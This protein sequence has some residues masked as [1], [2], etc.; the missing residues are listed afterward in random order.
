MER[1][2]LLSKLACLITAMVMTVAPLSSQEKS[3]NLAA[4]GFRYLVQNQRMVEANQVL[5]AMPLEF[6]HR[7]DIRESMVMLFI[8]RGD[9][10]LAL[11]H[12]GDLAVSDPVAGNWMLA[13]IHARLGNI[14]DALFFLARHLEQPGH[15]PEREIKL[16]DA[17]SGFDRNRQW[18]ALWQREWYSAW[19]QDLAEAL[20]LF[21]KGET[22]GAAEI[23]ERLTNEHPDKAEIWLQHAVFYYKSGDRRLARAG[24]DRALSAGSGNLRL[25]NELT[26]LLIRNQ[27]YDRAL[28]A[29]DLLSQ[30]DPGCPE[31]LINRS[32]VYLFSGNSE[33]AK[34]GIE[35]LGSV[36]VVA[37]GLWFE[38]ARS[39]A[40]SEPENALGYIN[41]VIGDGEFNEACYN[42][43]A[44][45]LLK[46]NRYAEAV[47]DLT[48]SLDIDARQ[49]DV[50]FDRAEIRMKQGDSEGACSDWNRAL[51]LKHR[52]AADRI[53]QHCR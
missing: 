31:G 16:D 41:R 11:R 43:R 51:R 46:L 6:L 53:S 33:K 52:K 38:A 48:M 27:E 2:K 35:A 15:Y 14:D 18:V 26:G 34:E 23:V 19:E 4:S 50:W 40:D 49:A 21:E 44:A 13:Q 9:F 8:S 37:S 17:F 12:A 24:A 29:I 7:Q 1:S 25:L 22:D 20:Y 32:L 36:G 42:T 45:I 10:D 39:L 3:D 47:S 5:A 28:K 30:L